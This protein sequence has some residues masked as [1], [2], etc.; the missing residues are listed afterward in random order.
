MEKVRH[1]A[2]REN[3]IE[4]NTWRGGEAGLRIL[5]QSIIMTYNVR[6]LSADGIMCG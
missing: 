4:E 2:H 5:S 3:V 6:K 1:K